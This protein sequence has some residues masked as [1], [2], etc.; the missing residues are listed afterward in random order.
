MRRRDREVTDPD[1]IREIIEACTCCHL[2]FQDK[3][4]VYIV[5]LSF[6]YREENGKYTF[7]FHGAGEGRKIELIQKEH[8]AGFEMETACQLRIGET[9]CN[10]TMSYQSII[11]GGRVRI[12]TENDEKAAALQA[13]ML[14]NT[15]KAQWDFP[16]H[17][18]AATT[19]FE[20]EA[21]EL[22]CKVHE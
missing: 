5:P 8:Y 17:M 4:K 18:L 13:I 22:S 6:G 15:G 21:E 19:V 2:G 14:H 16:E 3:S 11:G 1:R 20:L 7:Y 12:L 9:A 10:H